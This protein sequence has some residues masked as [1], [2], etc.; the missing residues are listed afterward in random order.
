MSVKIMG[1]VWDAD[2]KPTLRFVLLAYADHADHEGKSI[3]PSIK[4]LAEKTG[5]TKRTIQTSTRDLEKL[6]WLIPDGTGPKGTNRWRI[7]LDI[8]GESPAPPMKETA[9]GDE[10]VAGGGMNLTAP[11]GES[12]APEPLKNHQLKPSNNKNKRG[13]R[14]PAVELCKRI[15]FRY[16][17]KSLWKTID[18]NVGGE[19]VDLLRWGRIMRK[20][21]LSNFNI[22]NYRGMLENFNR[23]RK[24]DDNIDYMSDKNRRKYLKGW[25]DD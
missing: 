20:W 1:I 5:Y 4:L 9:Q 21:R 19:L 23:D 6:G 17:H 15:I 11:R 24:H 2:L 8:G 14:P 13:D 25:F 12:P 16:P 3:F 18:R 22:T 10:S 7:P